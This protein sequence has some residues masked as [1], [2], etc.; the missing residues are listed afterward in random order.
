MNSQLKDYI[1]RLCY[2]FE[3]CNHELGMQP[4]NLYY[5]IVNLDLYLRQ[6]LVI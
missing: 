2:Q 3:T 5:E 4:V 1:Y 6:V